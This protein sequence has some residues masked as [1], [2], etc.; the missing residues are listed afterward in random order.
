[1]RGFGAMLSDV[2]KEKIA[3]DGEAH[4]GGAGFDVS[5]DAVASA[6]L[7]KRDQTS[8]KVRWSSVRFRSRRPAVGT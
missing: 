5:L 8:F 1:M 2:I 7:K 4:A 6:P 3:D